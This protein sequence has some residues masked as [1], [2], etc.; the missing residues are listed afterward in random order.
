MSPPPPTLRCFD[1][2]LETCGATYR[3]SEVGLA[4]KP[5]MHVAIAEVDKMIGDG[6]SAHTL[7]TATVAYVRTDRTGDHAASGVNR[8][9]RRARGAYVR[10]W[11]GLLRR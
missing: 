7:V 6:V 8:G 2:E 1:I 3:W 11:L 10:P 4:F 9:L 5:L